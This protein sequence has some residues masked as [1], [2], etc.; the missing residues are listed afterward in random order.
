MPR[1]RASWGFLGLLLLGVFAYAVTS[2][3]TRLGLL[4]QRQ[5][6]RRV[7]EPYPDRHT[8]PLARSPWG[9]WLPVDEGF[10]AATTRVVVRDKSADGPAELEPFSRA[11]GASGPSLELK[12]RAHARR[13]SIIMQ[14]IGITVFGLGLLGLLISS[15]GQRGFENW[16]TVGKWGGCG[17]LCRYRDGSFPDGSNRALTAYHREMGCSARWGSGGRS[18][19]A[20]MYCF[21]V[22]TPSFPEPG[23]SVPGQSGASSPFEEGRPLGEPNKG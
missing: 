14:Y 20:R 13:V 12:L 19:L 23:V 22:L 1:A 8:T 21:S 18:L 7:V 9:T 2:G 15:K 10:V 3:A 4:G 11:L 5:E 16:G 17:E 6:A